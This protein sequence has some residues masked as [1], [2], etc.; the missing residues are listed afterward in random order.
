[1]FEYFKR[2]YS[3]S[4]ESFYKLVKKNLKDDKKQFIVTA[5]PETFMKAEQDEVMNKM[6]L[7]KN[8]TIVPDGIG[9]VKASKI[10]GF[11]VKERIPGIDI[12]TKLLEYGNELKKAYIFL[13]QKKK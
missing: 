7:D 10:I 13:G 2:L 11:N 1:M 12:A 6:L 4:S 5:N 9:I 8:T 3:K